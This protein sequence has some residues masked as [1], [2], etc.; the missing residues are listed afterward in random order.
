M[1]CSGS[2]RYKLPIGVKI[3][4]AVVV[5]TGVLIGGIILYEKIPGLFDI[6]GL[7]A[8]SR[9]R[10]LERELRDE[11]T[12]LGIR[13]STYQ[14][15]AGDYQTELADSLADNRELAEK[16]AGLE[17]QLRRERAIL[18][19]FDSLIASTEGPIRAAIGALDEADSGVG[20]IE[21]LVR[22][23]DGGFKAIPENR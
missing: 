17:S 12:A 4:V 15:L 14:K 23:L 22:E 19:R 7:D 21:R 10:S 6:L 16:L 11:I 8:M 18:D 5:I 2:W 3:G 9:Q 1:L 13:E 20:N